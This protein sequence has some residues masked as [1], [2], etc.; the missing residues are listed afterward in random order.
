LTVQPWLPPA[1]ITELVAGRSTRRIADSAL[2]A[3]LS[4]HLLLA[5]HVLR[6]RVSADTALRHAVEVLSQAQAGAP[7][8]TALTLQRGWFGSWV[9]HCLEPPEDG[10]PAAA[11]HRLSNLAAAAAWRAAVDATVETR[12]LRGAIHLPTLGTAVL[13][14]DD[15]TADRPARIVVRDRRITVDDGTLSAVLMPH[16]T[17]TRWLPLRQLRFAAGGQPWRPVLDDLDPLR[18]CYG[19]PPA[20]RLDEPSLGR[21]S[22]LLRQAWV[23]L[24]THAPAQATL[25]R[26]W[27][28]TLVPLA[29]AGDD[30]NLSIS[31]RASLNSLALS[32]PPDPA[33][34]AVAL[35]HEQSHD[36]LN[37]LMQFVL[38]ADPSATEVFFAPWRVD[39]RP[40]SGMLHGIYAFTAVAELWQALLSVPGLGATAEAQLA[41][42]RVQ[43]HAA[44]DALRDTAALTDTGTALMAACR[45][46]LA[47][48]DRSPVPADAQR[49]ALDDLADRHSA[50]LRRNR[51]PAP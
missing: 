6:D 30:A 20:G 9:S 26:Q 49:R 32:L 2:S 31:A 15:P 48:L 43:L 42:R 1:S 46:R 16:G 47:R 24:A 44:L 33:A 45:Q 37:G 14:D 38:L 4:R 41:Q 5:R 51:S 3:A 28:H 34:C 18:D 19:S 10:R 7:Q 13:A 40:L 11:L 12:T 27:I 25:V 35:V 36:M 22:A 39:A 21:W 23:L 8:T 50:W 17:S 29:P